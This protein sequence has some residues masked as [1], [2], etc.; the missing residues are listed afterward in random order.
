M[1]GSDDIDALIAR[2]A[3][4]DRKAFAA[5]YEHE[6]AR[7]F[8]VALWFLREDGP[9][10]DALQ[11]T[12]MRVWQ[13]AGT[14]RANGLSG[15]AWLTALVREACVTRL[16]GARAQAPS[17]VAADISGRLYGHG[18]TA[19]DGAEPNA[20]ALCLRELP[21]DRASLLRRAWTE[22]ICYAEMSRQ[23]GANPLDIRQG[24]RRA[25]L[26]LRECLSQ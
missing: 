19:E 25:I 4:G 15:Q 7:L 8:G 26:Q 9:A 3:M 10:E 11:D 22:G 18:G 1:A 12:F 16:R 6:S 5:L 13:S 21:P 24:L 17:D 14:Y 23:T 2:V 20:L